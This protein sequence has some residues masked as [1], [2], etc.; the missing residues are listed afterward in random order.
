MCRHVQPT[1]WDARALGVSTY[2]VLYESDIQFKQ[3]VSIIIKQRQFGHYTVKVDPLTIKK[4]LH[5]LDFFYCDT[6]IEPY[7]TKDQFIS[8]SRQEISVSEIVE[9]DAIEKICKTAFC[10]DRFHRDFNI[11]KQISDQRYSLWLRDLWEGKEVY[12]LMHSESVAGFFAFS[13]NKIL[14]HALSQSFRG[15]GLAK[16]FWSA[17]CEKLFNQGFSEL[18]SS[19]SASNLAA[20]NLYASLGFRFRKPLDVYH[21]LFD[22]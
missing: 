5:E 21:W 10:Y 6:L 11:D 19:I 13:S 15:K 2:E 22:E 8:Y 9:L 3:T 17:A 20:L 7:C 16:Y 1:P 18:I 12:S 14:L 4:V